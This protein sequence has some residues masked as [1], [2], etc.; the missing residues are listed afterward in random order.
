MT[1]GLKTRPNEQNDPFR[2]WFTDGI[3]RAEPKTAK[4]RG[5][6]RPEIAHG[7]YT[8]GVRISAAYR[9]A[10]EV[11]F[12]NLLSAQQMDVYHALDDVRER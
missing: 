6:F 10:V 11:V 1:A 9:K 8:I 3:L 4:G 7:L 12:R 5:Q 2:L